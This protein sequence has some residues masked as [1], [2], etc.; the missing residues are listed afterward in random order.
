M[1]IVGSQMQPTLNRSAEEKSRAAAGRSPLPKMRRIQADSS[2]VEIAHF[3]K[4]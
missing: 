2:P 1:A 4:I 3:V